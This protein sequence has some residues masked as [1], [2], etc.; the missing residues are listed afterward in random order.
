[1][2]EHLAPFSFGVDFNSATNHP[3][4]TAD[5]NLVHDID[6]FNN[7]VFICHD[8]VDFVKR[9]VVWTSPGPSPLVLLVE[10]RVHDLKATGKGEVDKI[11]V[12]FISITI[13]EGA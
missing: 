1:M 8:R 7:L 10:E 3:V 6:V 11:L 12:S 4:I 13:T 5:I 2:V 9:F